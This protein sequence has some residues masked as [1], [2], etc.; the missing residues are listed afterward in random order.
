VATAEPQASLLESIRTILAASPVPRRC[1]E[2]GDI[3]PP[4]NSIV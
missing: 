3:I 4:A 2:F 1:R